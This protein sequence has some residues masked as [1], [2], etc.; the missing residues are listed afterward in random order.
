MGIGTG[1][2]ALLKLGLL[3]YGEIRE[4]GLDWPALAFYASVR[5]VSR[6]VRVKVVANHSPWLRRTNPG[7]VYSLPVSHS[8]GRFIA[9][10]ADLERFFKNA[11]IVTVYVDLEGVPTLDP[12]YNPNGSAGAVEGLTSPDGRIFGRMAHANG[13]GL[14]WPRISPEK[15]RANLCYRCRVFLLNRLNRC[16][17]YWFEFTI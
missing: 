5:H 4:A 16:F 1:F 10:P 17:R 13:S 8:E 3:P 6:F 15:R 14:M 9:R 2:Q 11:Q 7:E 12:P